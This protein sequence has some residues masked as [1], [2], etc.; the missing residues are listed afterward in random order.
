MEYVWDKIELLKAADR[1]IREEEMVEEIYM[2]LPEDLR[3]VLDEEKILQEW[4][5]QQLSDVLQS[6]DRSFL[7]KRR[8]EERFQGQSRPKDKKRFDR[9]R[10][11]KKDGSAVSKSAGSG[12]DAGKEQKSKE[13]DKE[14]KKK[15]K[16]DAKTG[17][18]L[19]RACRHCDEWHFEYDCPKKPASYYADHEQFAKEDEIPSDAEFSESSQS[20]PES[21][22]Y[23]SYHTTTN[24]YRRVNNAKP[25]FIKN[26]HRI[27]VIEA[28]KAEV[29][30]TGI[31]YLSAEPCPIRPSLGSPPSNSIPLH[32]GVADTGG[33]SIIVKDM[34]PPDIAIRQSPLNPSFRG[35]GDASTAT[36]GY[37]VIPTYLPNHA[38]LSGDRRSARMLMLWIEYQVVEQCR[39]GFLIGRDATKAYTI[40]VEESSGKVLI[41]VG[42]DPIPFKVPIAEGTRFATSRLDS[43]VLLEASSNVAVHSAVSLPISYKKTSD[44]STHLF[45]PRRFVDPAEGTCG[46][47]CFAIFND[48]VNRIVFINSSDRPMRLAKGEI[49]G[50]FEPVSPNTPISYFNIGGGMTKSKINVKLSD[51]GERK[52]AGSKHAPISGEWKAEKDSDGHLKTKPKYSPSVGTTGKN[53]VLKLDDEADEANEANG[54]DPFGLTSESEKEQ[55]EPDE[56]IKEPDDLEWNVN[57]RLRLRR[58]IEMLELLRKRKG[59]LWSGGLGW[60]MSRATR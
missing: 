52:A 24:G 9:D 56:S 17:R 53:Y 47:A 7:A 58:K 39:A 21:A 38:A 33:A 40:D 20:S 6:K 5:V 10:P 11:D 49:L 30:G 41:R 27:L 50:T 46:S 28:P 37:A 29:V 54:V 60:D 3:L 32:C 13:E 4:S 59:V 43:R 12:R 35:I 55:D 36:L 16:K 15:W 18:V 19:K 42:D 8:R 23:S 14:D 51:E 44:N 31:A 45:S 48:D 2:G 25:I 26:G 34:V 22:T 1:R 57:P